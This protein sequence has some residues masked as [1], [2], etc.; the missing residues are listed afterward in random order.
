ML[1]LVGLI[2][3]FRAF[4]LLRARA[5]AF[6]HDVAFGAAIVFGGILMHYLVA[7][8]LAA[9]RDKSRAQQSMT[10]RARALPMAVPLF[11]RKSPSILW[12]GTSRGV[13]DIW[14]FPKSYR[15]VAVVQSGR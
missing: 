4:V 7:R 5:E 1:A 2:S 3:K 11:L 13:S 14:P 6:S 9:W 8:G 12:S 10:N 15:R